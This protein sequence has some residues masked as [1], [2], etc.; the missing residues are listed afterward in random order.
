MHVFMCMWHDVCCRDILDLHDIQKDLVIMVQD[1]GETTDRIEVQVGHAADRVEKGQ[2][3]LA[4][5]VILKSKKRNLCIAISLVVGIPI[6]ILLLII[7]I[8]LAVVI[9]KK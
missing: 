3:K 2:K 1:Q 5:T 6:I 8:V 7:I 9:P 4:D